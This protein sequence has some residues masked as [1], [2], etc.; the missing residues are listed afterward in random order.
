MQ[1]DISFSTNE[2]IILEFLSDGLGHPKEEVMKAL[3]PDE[4]MSPY[5]FYMAI[6]RL[7]KK[8]DRV[9]ETVI[10]QAI[11]YKNHYRHVKLLPRDFD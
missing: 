10:A 1:E 4:L 2:T 7:N 9:G 3:D 11:G 5:A 6:V 8:L